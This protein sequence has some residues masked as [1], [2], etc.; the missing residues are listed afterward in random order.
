MGDYILFDANRRPSV[1]NQE[2]RD[3]MYFT[4]PVAKGRLTSLLQCVISQL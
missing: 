2:Q 4:M 3:M 1:L